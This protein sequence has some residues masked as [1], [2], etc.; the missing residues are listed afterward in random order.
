MFCICYLNITFKFLIKL[1]MDIPTGI[2]VAVYAM[3]IT[4][5]RNRKH[6]ILLTLKTGSPALAFIPQNYWYTLHNKHLSKHKC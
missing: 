5:R 4:K 6:F 3:Y 1:Y 2:A